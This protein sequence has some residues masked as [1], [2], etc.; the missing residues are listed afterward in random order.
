MTRFHPASFALLLALAAAAHSQTA[1]P[2]PEAHAHAPAL[3]S[4]TLSVTVAGKQTSFSPADLQSMP[5]H[6]VT[7]HN[8][9][10]NVDEV[11]TGVAVS[12]LLARFG[13]SMQGHGDRRIY[14]SYLKAEGSDHYFVLYSTSELEPAVHTGDVIVA[15]M[16]DGKPL[17]ADGAFKLVATEDKLPARWVRNVTALTLIEP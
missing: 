11:Y 7:V 9:H 1:A 17:G 2:M 12:D 8:G 15:L 5:Q 3:P 4:T 10:S 16:V 6:T 14:H 13:I